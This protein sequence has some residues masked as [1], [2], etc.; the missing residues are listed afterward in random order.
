MAKLHLGSAGIFACRHCYQL[1]YAS[2]RENTD[3]RA[4]RRA[5]KIRDRLKW[6]PGILSGHGIKPKGM[7]WRTYQRLTI[8]HDANVGISPNYMARRMRMIEENLDEI[9][10]DLNLFRKISVWF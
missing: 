7:Y 1:A 2:Q 3:D 10:A 9:A 8:K 5:D 4:T 6:E